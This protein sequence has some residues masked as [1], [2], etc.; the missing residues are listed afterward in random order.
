KNLMVDRA[1][2]PQSFLIMSLFAALVNALKVRMNRTESPSSPKLYPSPPPMEPSIFSLSPS[3]V[4]DSPDDQESPKG[5]TSRSSTCSPPLQARVLNSDYTLAETSGDSLSAGYR[6]SSRD[7]DSFLP[8]SAAEFSDE[9]IWET[10]R[11]SDTFD[12]CLRL[13]LSKIEFDFTRFSGNLSVVLPKVGHDAWATLDCICYAMSAIC[14]WSFMASEEG[15]NVLE[16]FSGIGGMRCALASAGV[17]CKKITAVDVNTES[18]KV[19]EKSYGDTPKP[20]N[21][22]SAGGASTT[23]ENKIEQVIRIVLLTGRLLTVGVKWFESMKS[24][25]WTMSPPCQPYTRQGNQQDSDDHRANALGRI[26]EVLGKMRNPPRVIVLENVVHFERSRSLCQLLHVLEDIGGYQY[27][28]FML[29][30]MQFGFPNSRSRFY[31]VAL[32]DASAFEKLPTVPRSDARTPSLVLYNN[33]P[34][35][36]CVTGGGLRLKSEASRER[37]CPI[38][39]EDGFELITAEIECDCEYTPREVGQF[40]DAADVLPINSTV[41]KETLQKPSSFCFD[42]VSSKSLQSMCF[43]KA[44]RKFHNGTGSVL[45]KSELPTTPDSWDEMMRPHFSD[46]QSMTEL[47]GQLRYFTPSEIAR[48]QGFPLEGE[49]STRWRQTLCATHEGCPEPAGKRAKV[50]IVA[51]LCTDFAGMKVSERA[52]IGMLGNS[53]NPQVV[54]KIIE[55]CDIGNLVARGE[56]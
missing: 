45:L 4:C 47:F 52:L 2:Y 54:S 38:P 55:I 8:A 24:D 7:F 9:V 14:F 50:P 49:T 37:V 5:A 56:A 30:P 41:P 26:I 1:R 10:R 13:I 21:I 25:M 53:L 12:E 18:N 36:N 34:C 16:L 44:Y 33:V 43:T 15:V 32:R 6:Y 3:S 31:L 51:S 48:L 35:V 40:L 23:P 39:D 19:Y 17:R 42:I 28:G 22:A 29:N 46:L 20:K 11:P 27:R